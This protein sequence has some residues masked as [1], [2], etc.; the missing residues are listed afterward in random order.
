MTTHDHGVWTHDH[1]YL[2]HGHEKAESRA[3]IVAWLTAA[4]MVVEIVVG[5]MAGSMALLADGWHMGTHAIALGISVLAYV[6]ARRFAHDARFAF[7]TWKIEVLGG[8]TSAVLLAVVGFMMGY[9]SVSRLLNPSRIHFDNAIMVAVVG[10]IVNWVCAWMLKS[11]RSH[12]AAHGHHP[13][14]HDRG[15]PVNRP[16]RRRPCRRTTEKADLARDNH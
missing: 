1:I 11:G 4:F 16:Q 9:E 12:D 13:H 10:L 15:C 2:G 5:L 6:Y 14:G 3:R 7:G 8:Y